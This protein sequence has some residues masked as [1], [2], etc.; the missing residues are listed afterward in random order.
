MYYIKHHISLEE[1]NDLKKIINA[2]KKEFLRRI[3]YSEWINEAT[4]N[5]SKKHFE[6][7]E[8]YIGTSEE[9]WNSNLKELEIDQVSHHL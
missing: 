3:Q 6:K 4:K 9:L 8:E 5:Y 2:V 1:R 7:I